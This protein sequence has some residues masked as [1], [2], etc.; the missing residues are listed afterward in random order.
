MS[1]HPVDVFVKEMETYSCADVMLRYPLDA[2]VEGSHVCDR[3]CAPLTDIDGSLPHVAWKKDLPTKDPGAWPSTSHS[4]KSSSGHP[5]WPILAE[6]SY[7]LSGLPNFLEILRP[8][9]S[10]E[11]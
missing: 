4:P 10:L 2:F 11:A 5:S 9:I 6:P 8:Q 1:R 7:D 3:I